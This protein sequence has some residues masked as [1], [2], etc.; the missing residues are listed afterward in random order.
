MA[1]TWNNQPSA[2]SFGEVDLPA[3][4]YQTQDYPDID[5][6]RFVSDWVA[7]P[8]HNFGMLFRIADE[9]VFRSMLFGSSDNPDASLR[10]KL[11]VTYKICAVSVAHF[12][13]S[14]LGSEVQFHD[15]S[16]SAQTWYWSFG[17]GYFSN[18]KNPFHNYAQLGKYY[19]CL[20]ITDSC[21]SS[22]SCDTIYVCHQPD[23][24]F[25][26]VTHGHL[27]SFTVSSYSPVPWYWSFGDDFFSDLQNPTHYFRDPGTYYVCLT[28]K[29]ICNQQ[30]FCDS[31]LFQTNG[32]NNLS[33]EV[34]SLYPV[35]ASDHLNM[36]SP[37]L[38]PGPG[39]INIINEAGAVIFR[40]HINWTS[41]GF[42]DSI[43]LTGFSPGFYYLRMIANHATFLK[44][45]VMI[46]T[47]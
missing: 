12:A 35:P 24:R 4:L 47:L 9:S 14:V 23:P 32:V 43:D 45:F 26:F 20:S 36:A 34:F 46:K 22:Q 33:G 6:T 41:R 38:Q 13:Y 2:T 10:P 29:N 3:S 17:D 1:V 25:S 30:T 16:S 28:S 15:S 40:K 42:F 37:G 31:V 21:G 18:L 5:I 44:K 8:Q 39:E 27:V 11:V 7:D 19:A